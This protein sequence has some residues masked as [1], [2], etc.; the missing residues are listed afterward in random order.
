MCGSWGF[1]TVVPREFTDAETL[2]R[3]AAMGA[4]ANVH[5]LDGEASYALL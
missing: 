3:T 5:H 1:V 4:D 2:L